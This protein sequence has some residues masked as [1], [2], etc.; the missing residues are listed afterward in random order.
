MHHLITF[1][2]VKDLV[3]YYRQSH[4]LKRDA[5]YKVKDIKTPKKYLSHRKICLNIFPTERNCDKKDL[6]HIYQNI[7][8]S[9][10]AK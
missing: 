3:R 5:Y 8:K 2:I 6:K 10:F 9:I 4:P 7:K 1:Y